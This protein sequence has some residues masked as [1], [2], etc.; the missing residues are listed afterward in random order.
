VAYTP[1]N[2]FIAG[3]KNIESIETR[4]INIML[5]DKF[6]ER[7]EVMKSICFTFLSIIRVR[8]ILAIVGGIGIN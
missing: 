3:L 7:V 8:T 4:L 1:L 5:L 2:V 6:T